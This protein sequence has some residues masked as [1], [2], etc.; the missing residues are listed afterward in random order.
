MNAQEVVESSTA[1][2]NSRRDASAVEPD[3]R[4]PAGKSFG[5]L[6]RG[7]LGAGSGQAMVSQVTA[8]DA[9]PASA[10]DTEVKQVARKAQ[11]ESE[12]GAPEVSEGEEEQLKDDEAVEEVDAV[13]GGEEELVDQAAA[14]A[15]QEVQA[16]VEQEVQEESSEI[17]VE[18]ES[19][20]TDTE[21][22]TEAEVDA[23]VVSSDAP[24]DVE[25]LAAAEQ[26]VNAGREFVAREQLSSGAAVEK[27]AAAGEP[28]E[29]P[30][31]S[32]QNA[33]EAIVPQAAHEVDEAAEEIVDAVVKQ[34]K[35]AQQVVGDKEAQADA[36]PAPQIQ[37]PIAPAAA[38]GGEGPGD[39]AALD[40]S[41]R[42]HLVFTEQAF[43]VQGLTSLHSSFSEALRGKAGGSLEG[44]VK[45]QAT[46]VRV[47]DLRSSAEAEKH[48]AKAKPEQAPGAH[49]ARMLEQVQKVLEEAVRTK[50]SNTIVVRLDPP[51]LGAL[52][53]RLTHRGDELFGR[54][55]PESPE[56]EAILRSRSHELQQILAASGLK[57][58]NVHV[59]IGQERSA[60][61]FLFQQQFEGRGRRDD[62]E[63][64]ARFGTERS[65]AQRTESYS[66]AKE[67]ASGWVA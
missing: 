25:T 45:I 10:I 63:R 4:A 57:A 46:D 26:A 43:A 64:G 34:T 54:I 60:D 24:Q 49:S 52:T 9:V 59:S 6:I 44:M 15:P 56:V 61:A 20:E 48:A 14:P 12:E 51:Q 36:E 47:S 32:V 5:E 22:R 18:E 19:I 27:P 38:A 58:E 28:S 23:V 37:A 7:L 16:S 17:V 40:G 65:A 31:E 13:K 62:D 66:G 50:D 42:R 35:I 1:V 67:N 30:A 39:E 55:I 41:N 33:P 29:K 2:R 53:V 21:Q 3:N 8:V 11:P